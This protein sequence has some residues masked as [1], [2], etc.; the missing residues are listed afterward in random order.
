M[1]ESMKRGDAS[2]RAE[3]SDINTAVHQEADILML[4]GETAF[5]KGKPADAVTVMRES[6]EQAECERL[7][8][9]N[10]KSFEDLQRK[11][12]KEI[13]K[14]PGRPSI[15]KSLSVLRLAQGNQICVS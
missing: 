15:D 8:H 7:N 5:T 4:S 3:I 6:I 9:D 10:E 12:E 2:T 14:I 1:L 13:K 11:R